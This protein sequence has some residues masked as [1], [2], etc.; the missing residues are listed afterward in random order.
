MKVVLKNK[1]EFEKLKKKSK[2]E[3]NKNEERNNWRM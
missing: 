3:S 2:N 1:K